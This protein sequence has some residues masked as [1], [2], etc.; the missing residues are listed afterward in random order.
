M[1]KQRT[2]PH[3]GVGLRAYTPTLNDERPF[4]TDLFCPRCER[5][6]ARSDTSPSGLVCVECN[7][8]EAA[9]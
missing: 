7:R 8:P 9:T 3:C 2:C 1:T 5:N 6:Y 4:N